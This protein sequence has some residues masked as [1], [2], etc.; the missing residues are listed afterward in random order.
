M[1]QQEVAARPACRN[2][3]RGLSSPGV[4]PFLANQERPRPPSS[5]SFRADAAAP[6]ACCPS[7]RIEAARTRLELGKGR[8]M[9]KIGRFKK[10]PGEYRGQVIPLSVQAKSVRI[11]P[12][13]HPTGTAP[14]PRVLT[15]KADVGPP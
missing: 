8:I 1:C 10:V 3:G 14:S 2:G 15:G 6:G 13:T 9:T 12:A 7:M 5:T 11:A 4:P